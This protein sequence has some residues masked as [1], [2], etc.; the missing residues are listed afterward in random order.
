MWKV[1]KKIPKGRPLEIA[2]KLNVTPKYLENGTS[3]VSIINGHQ[4]QV[5]DE[6]IEFAELFK[7]YGN[8]EML[9]SFIEKLKKY[10]KFQKEKYNGDPY[11]LVFKLYELYGRKSK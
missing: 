4:V 1:G 8:A 3:S 10:K 9:N 7:K 11:K 2:A 6:F 5:S